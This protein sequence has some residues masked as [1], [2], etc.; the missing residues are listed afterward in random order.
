MK[1]RAILYIRVSTDEQADKGY[2]LAYQE[3]RLRSYCEINNIEPVS[4]FQ[5]DHSAKTFD[6]PVFREMMMF[7]KNRKNRGTID[8]LLVIKWDR[9]SR[10][11][12][13]SYQMIHEF[14]KLGI[15][16]RA[17][18]QHLDLNIP[19]AKLMLAF[20][21]ASPEVENDRRALNIFSGMRRAKKEG[22]WIA[23]APLGYKNVRDENNKPAIAPDE[24]KAALVRE[25]FEELASGQYNLEEVRR[26]LSKKGMKC[27]RS[28][29]QRLMRNPVYAGKIHVPAFKDESEA[30][31]Q[32]QHESILEENLFWQVQ[33]IL[34]GRT[35]KNTVKK[36]MLD[37]LPLRGFLQCPQCNGILTGSASKGKMGVRYFYY[38]CREGCPERF[39]A[40]LANDAI[41]EIFNGIQA[42][43]EVIELYQDI[44]K[45]IF[46]D[47]NTDRDKKLQGIQTEV[48]S[49]TKRIN[50]A[51]QMML[52]KEME[53]SEYKDIKDRYEGLNSKL[54][55]DKVAIEAM[56]GNYGIYLKS[57]MAFLKNIS[58][59]YQKSNL[60]TKRKIVS[61]I[62][63]GNIIFEKNQVRTPQ[64][65]E[66]VKL[67]SLED[68]N[69]GGIKKGSHSY[70]QM[71]SRL[72]E[73]EGFEPPDLLQSPVF[74]T[75]AINRSTTPLCL[76]VY[77]RS[78][79]V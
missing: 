45:D 47:S 34:D 22:R 13:D 43:K 59:H 33:E 8:Y 19:E 30:Y 68:S 2:S 67:I 63:M 37:E 32:G 28:N 35:P 18:E 44:L 73:E 65:T 39:K 29:F 52:D 76:L 42:K 23:S 20:Y 79:N 54:L 1:K 61:S 78:A 26:R 71:R 53:R 74:K 48:D 31:V 10:N 16:V 66:I 77:L 15:E 56:D 36:K 69:L 5:E 60:E 7:T 57:G 75:G 25:A 49:N 72:V 27:S 21:L 12:K 38:H 40:H 3:D 11:T 24:K 9:F 58:N 62:F 51:M 64:F 50:T 55:R 6:R 17:I 41:V 70:N 46:K 4:V 14:H